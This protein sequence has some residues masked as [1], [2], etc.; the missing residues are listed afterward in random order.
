MESV[1]RADSWIIV[2]LSLEASEG[3]VSPRPD[4]GR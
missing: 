2:A 3:S 1:S 4:S